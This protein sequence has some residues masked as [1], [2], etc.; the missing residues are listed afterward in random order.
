[1]DGHGLL[2]SSKRFPFRA[3]VDTLVMAFAVVVLIVPV[4]SPQAQPASQAVPA[5]VLAGCE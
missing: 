5:P 3:H 1:M 2:C 4:V